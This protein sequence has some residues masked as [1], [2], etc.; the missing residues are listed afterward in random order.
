MLKCFHG[1]SLCFNFIQR[2]V[3][4]RNDYTEPCYRLTGTDMMDDDECATVGGMRIG[5]GNQST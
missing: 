3:V 1:N 4:Y 5:R 2:R